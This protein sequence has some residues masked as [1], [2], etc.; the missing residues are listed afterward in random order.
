M[1]VYNQANRLQVARQ[2]LPLPPHQCTTPTGCTAHKH[3]V[4]QSQ[5]TLFTCSHCASPTTAHKH[6]CLPAQLASAPAQDTSGRGRASLYTRRG[7]VLWIFVVRCIYSLLVLAW[8]GEAYIY[9]RVSTQ[10][11]R[12]G[13]LPNLT[14]TL[15]E[16]RTY[17][18][19][20]A[21]FFYLNL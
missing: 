11:H 19:W 21:Y 10:L 14:I 17:N 6:L 2:Y 13:P 7:F 16:C 4:D 1:I 8:R 20:I 12:L 15:C 18:K 3:K 5:D 9:Y